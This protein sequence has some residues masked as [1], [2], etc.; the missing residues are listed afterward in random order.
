MLRRRAS[1]REGSPRARRRDA[2]PLPRRHRASSRRRRGSRARHLLSPRSARVH[3]NL[4]VGVRLGESVRSPPRSSPPRFATRWSPPR[5]RPRHSYVAST[6]CGVAASGVCSWVAGVGDRD[7]QNILVD[8]RDGSLVHIDFGCAFGTAGRVTH[9]GADAVSRDGGDARSVSAG[10]REGCAGG[11]HARDDA[12]AS[13]GSAPASR[14]HGRVPRRERLVALARG[15]A[16]DPHASKPALLRGGP[17]GERGDTPRIRVQVLIPRRSGARTRRRARCARW[18][19][20]RDSRATRANTSSSKSRTRG[21]NSN[22]EIRATSPSR[23]A[24]RNTREPRAL[25]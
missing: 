9:P 24:P 14:H 1:G 7:P 11:G 12:R 21:P 23:S 3:V 25:G 13:R 20:R 16:L 6:L 22:S 10:G 4:R 2:D 18:R 17:G 5:V 15:E 8:L 19:A